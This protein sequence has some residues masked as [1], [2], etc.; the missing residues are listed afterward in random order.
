MRPACGLGQR[1]ADVRL[2]AHIPSTFDALGAADLLFWGQHA[3][4]ITIS[5]RKQLTI[6]SDSSSQLHTLSSPSPRSNVSFRSSGG[7]GREA[8][9]YSFESRVFRSR[10]SRTKS[11]GYERLVVVVVVTVLVS[12]HS[13][14]NCICIIRRCVT[15]ASSS[16]QDIETRWLDRG[17]RGSM[18]VRSCS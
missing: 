17:R 10:G 1:G 5:V 3:L 12:M 8:R 7:V 16:S 9:G 15:V 4:S 11:G 2:D 14:A 13:S 6:R 18:A